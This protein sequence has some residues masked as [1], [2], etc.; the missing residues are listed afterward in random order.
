MASLLH[1]ALGDGPRLA[2]GRDRGRADH[3]AQAGR[4]LDGDAQAPRF[5]RPPIQSAPS[6]LQRVV[7]VE[8]PLDGGLARKADVI[9]HAERLRS[10]ELEGARKRCDAGFR[11][12]RSGRL[13]L[14]RAALA[15]WR[16]R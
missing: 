16:R 8:I 1:R 5:P 15:R 6:R 7:G 4:L 14:D 9:G 10:V 12:I 2:G 11:R 13:G 3:A